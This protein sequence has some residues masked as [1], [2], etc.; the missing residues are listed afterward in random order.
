[1]AVETLRPGAV[2]TG[3]LLPEPVEIITVVPMGASIKLIGKGL[4]SK[5]VREPVL[6]QAQVD[7]L[8]ITPAREPFDGDPARFRL[9]IEALRLGLAYEYD[10]HFALS[11]AR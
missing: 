5:Q 8:R 9:G 11:V 1:M 10:P 4:N 2:V 3:P 6:T 7:Q